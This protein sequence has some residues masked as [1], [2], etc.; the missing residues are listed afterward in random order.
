[1][2]KC[3]VKFCQI[4]CI[5]DG[6]SRY[7]SIKVLT[8]LQRNCV[9]LSSLK[10]QQFRKISTLMHV[11]SV[12]TADKL[13]ICSV[14]NFYFLIILNISLF[15]SSHNTKLL[16]LTFQAE[17]SFL[18]NKRSAYYVRVY[19][20]QKGILLMPQSFKLLLTWSVVLD[21]NLDFHSSLYT[22]TNYL[23]CELRCK[24]CFERPKNEE[25]SSIHGG[26]KKNL[27]G[28]AFFTLVVVVWGGGGGT[29]I[30]WIQSEN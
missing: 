13:T 20:F 16:Y 30:I 17:C 8:K 3:N 26:K 25:S 7:C 22:C 12:L 19:K 14:T 21:I 4:F 6:Q 11:R 15:Q 27:L 23:L 2:S 29:W 5:N 18:K 28:D 1:M 9:S 24:L 10:I